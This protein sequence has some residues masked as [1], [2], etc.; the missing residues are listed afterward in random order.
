M[1][2]WYVDFTLPSNGTGTTYSGAWNV[3]TATEG[4]N[5]NDGDSI[6]F[7]RNDPGN[8]Q[9]LITIKA[10][11][12]KYIGWPKEGDD[13]YDVRP[14]DPRALWDTDSSNYVYQR[15]SIDNGA[16]HSLESGNTFYRWYFYNYCTSN[17]RQ[18]TIEIM[19]K[20][21]VS[22]Y[23]SYIYTYKYSSTSYDY[24][25]VLRVENSDNIYFKNTTIRG[26]A[27][28]N[29]T[30]NQL[31]KLYNS[32]ITFDDC[33]F[34][35]PSN[36]DTSTSHADSTKEVS[37]INNSTLYFNNCVFNNYVLRTCTSNTTVNAY[38]CMVYDSTLHFN[39]T[40]L[41]HNR[42][43]AVSNNIFSMTPHYWFYVS[44][45]T[46]NL[47]NNCRYRAWCDMVAGF[48]VTNGSN[49]NCSDFQV[50]TE[51]SSVNQNVVFD[52][53]NI[54]NVTISGVSGSVNYHTN[55]EDKN[56]FIGLNNSVSFEYFTDK[57][58]I[59]DVSTYVG[60]VIEK[61]R[62]N[63]SDNQ[64]INIS[65]DT[66]FRDFSVFFGTPREL[67][68]DNSEIGGVGL[69]YRS[70]NTSYAW[71][72]S[73]YTYK[74]SKVINSTITK[75]NALYLP[76]SY[77]NSSVNAIIYNCE[78]LGNN[79]VFDDNSGSSCKVNLKVLRNRGFSS[80]GSLGCYF[81]KIISSSFNMGELNTH[82]Y[83]YE[84]YISNSEIYRTNGAN[85]S[86]KAFKETS[87]GSL[88]ISELGAETIWIRLPAEGT[89]MITA[90][91]L[92][93]CASCTLLLSDVYFEVDYFDSSGFSHRI[94]SDSLV[95]DT[96]SSWS[97]SGTKIKL[98][99]SVTVSS[100]QFCPVRFYIPGY[101]ENL[102]VYID[103]K[104]D[105]TEV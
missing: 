38:C 6:W 49:I 8:G 3:F 98:T 44:N 29:Y 68:I 43:D 40:C 10:G 81:N 86:I 73:Y 41:E 76:S 4:A 24:S 84:G 63:Q 52:L 15:R 92:Y 82:K 2:D 46:V 74:N 50:D 56:Y 25:R 93:T 1:A 33:I 69:Y 5:V 53:W 91:M 105:V 100:A 19:S 9:K 79:Q 35:T 12:I 39:N 36:I 70:Y 30:Y 75:Y 26:A 80:V 60:D 11:D 87:N 17:S 85:Y 83:F 66:T 51:S 62:Y 72:G 22:V 42:T 104:V 27:S 21:N 61:L 57:I 64:I 7:R 102:F 48:Y 37:Y 55:V 78:S 71:Y 67:N 89:Y 18:R 14:S 59:M 16:V 20:S 65:D 77:V 103:P 90:Y 31:F 101:Y 47:I 54:G 28:T 34:K 23:H 13:L 97:G 58:D 94:V 88:C 32:I 99:C 95:N 96:T 45:C